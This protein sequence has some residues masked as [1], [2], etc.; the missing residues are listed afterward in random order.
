MPFYCAHFSGIQL[1]RKTR[2]GCMWIEIRRIHWRSVDRLRLRSRTD[3]F[4]LPRGYWC[5][6]TVRN[7]M[8]AVRSRMFEQLTVPTTHRILAC[9]NSQE[10]PLWKTSGM[11]NDSIEETHVQVVSY[12]SPFAQSRRTS[13]V[14]TM[15][16]QVGSSLGCRMRS[17]AARK[18]YGSLLKSPDAEYPYIRVLSEAL[19]VALFTIKSESILQSIQ[20]PPTP[21][22]QLTRGSLLSEK[23][24]DNVSSTCYRGQRVEIGERL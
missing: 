9:L 12:G 13:T 10:A 17:H 7:S 19:E 11:N 20:V 5:K 15:K 2:A 1:G 21:H 4:R 8:V 6:A 24:T 14:C 3:F 16:L 23:K 18:G 22:T